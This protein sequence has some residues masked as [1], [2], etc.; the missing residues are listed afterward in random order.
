MVFAA[1]RSYDSAVLGVVILSVCPSV[2]HTRA[3]WLNQRTYR[4]Y[5]YTTWKGNP[6]SQMWFSYSCAAADKISTD[7]RARAVSLRQLSYLLQ[8]TYSKRQNQFL[9]KKQKRKFHER[10]CQNKVILF[11]IRQTWVLLKMLSERVELSRMFTSLRSASHSPWY[12]IS[13]IRQFK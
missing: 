12:S 3:F 11:D 9:K 10:V 8:A 6:S 7:L 5:F 4:R 13:D 2:R 1:R